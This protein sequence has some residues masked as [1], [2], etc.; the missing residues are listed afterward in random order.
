MVIAGLPDPKEQQNP[1][2]HQ[3]PT[4]EPQYLTRWR[5]EPLGV[6]DQ[7]YQQP[8]TGGF[9]KHAEDGATN[10]EPVRSVSGLDPESDPQRLLLWVRQR[11]EHAEQRRAELV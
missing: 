5:I 11:F 9:G 10:D 3:S 8:L 4:H 6:V 1:L 7:A 2:G